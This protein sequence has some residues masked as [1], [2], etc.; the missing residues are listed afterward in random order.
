MV[1]SF[2]PAH[3]THIFPVWLP[4]TFAL[5]YPDDVAE[6][7]PVQQI[8]VANNTIR[9][10]SL[11]IFAVTGIVIG[12][13]GSIR[14]LRVT[15][16]RRKSH[17]NNSPLLHDAQFYWMVAFLFFGFM[18]TS[19]L[20]LHCLL[21]FPEKTRDSTQ[22]RALLFIADTYTTGVFG[23]SIWAA[24]MMESLSSAYVNI[25]TYTSMDP[26]EWIRNVWI[27]MNILGLLA[28]ACFLTGSASA[29]GEESPS[30]TLST[31]LLSRSLPLELWYLCPTIVWAGLGLEVMLL[32][33]FSKT[34]LLALLSAF[35]V[36][37]LAFFDAIICRSIGNAFLDLFTQ[38]TLMFL[39]TDVLFLGLGIWL[40]T[41]QK[42]Q[43]DASGQSG[44]ST[45]FKDN[46]Q[47]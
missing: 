35:S 13:T 19:G 10:P 24:C 33:H 20:F 31:L 37:G 15:M 36:F 18:N 1:C 47:A 26:K 2:F 4:R 34:L 17:N 5:L 27:I 25:K 23:I 45:T 29:T 7:C 39:G 21:P 28:I 12:L 40:E 38:P 16:S 22:E 44:T 41:R 42:T 6:A 46:K 11:A 9:R 14:L 43:Q 32:C 30:A 8:S 3:C